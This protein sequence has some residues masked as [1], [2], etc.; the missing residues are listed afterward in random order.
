MFL[1]K[2]LNKC[3]DELPEELK[4]LE[5]KIEADWS[6]EKKKYAM[7]LIRE[8]NNPEL[9]G[10]TDMKLHR[11]N[12]SPLVLVLSFSE[13]ERISKEKEKEAVMQYIEG[14]LKDINQMSRLIY[15]SYSEHYIETD[16]WEIMIEWF[17]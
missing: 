14:I 3:L 2:A 10:F 1:M 6:D 17:I 9:D 11:I 12:F 8:M 5:N 4:R 13:V 16:C 15:L 7:E